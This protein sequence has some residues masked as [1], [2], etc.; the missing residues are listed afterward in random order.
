M[1]CSS[2]SI[3]AHEPHALYE[4]FRQFCKEEGEGEYTAND[5]MTVYVYNLRE[6]LSTSSGTHVSHCVTYSSLLASVAFSVNMEAW[7][8]G[9]EYS[10]DADLAGTCTMH[11]VHSET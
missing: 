7:L 2:S 11:C 6:V 10:H 1:C 5:C 3:L 4:E 9:Q 8:L